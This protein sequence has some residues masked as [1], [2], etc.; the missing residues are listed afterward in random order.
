VVTHDVAQALAAS[1]RLALLENGK[2]YFQG[3]AAEFGSS[4]DSLVRSFR[5]GAGLANSKQGPRMD[6]NEHE[7]LNRRRVAP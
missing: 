4:E 3:T 5:D 1:D 7:D 6:T 2:I